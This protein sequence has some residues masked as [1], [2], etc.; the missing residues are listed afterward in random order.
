MKFVILVNVNHCLKM[1]I[2]FFILGF[3]FLFYH[4]TNYFH[5]MAENEKNIKKLML[6]LWVKNAGEIIATITTTKS[7]KVNHD[8]KNFTV[9]IRITVWHISTMHIIII[10]GDH[11]FY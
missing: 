4:K 11:D 5:F 1:F 2:F 9:E 8:K 7:T 6:Y 10:I 3:S